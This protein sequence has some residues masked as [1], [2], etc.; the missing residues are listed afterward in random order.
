MGNIVTRPEAGWLCRAHE[1]IEPVVKC[2]SFSEQEEGAAMTSQ[3]K[4]ED[5]I[6]DGPV[7]DLASVLNY[8]NLVFAGVLDWY[9]N[10]DAK[11]QIILSLD[12]ALVAFLTSSIFK[13]PAELSAITHSLTRGTWFLLFAMCLCLVG[14]IVS[15]L[16]CLWSRVFLGIK[17]DSIL[18]RE[19]EKIRAGAKA[20]SP[21]V[22]LFFKTISWLDH[23]TFQEQLEATDTAFH[24]KALASQIYLLSKRVYVKHI[25]VNAG[26]VLAGASLIFFLASG[27][28]YLAAVK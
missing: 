27:V 4:Q 3:H 9:K 20:Y 6:Q 11:A 2:G 8:S 18:G 7:P 22:M 26:F 25:W 12:G 21:N 16:I 19:R 14:S 10:A 13:S 28:S 23:D 15:A 5:H 24:I 1:E 17:K